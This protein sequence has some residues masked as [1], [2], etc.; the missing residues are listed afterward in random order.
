MMVFAV[1]PNGDKKTLSGCNDVASLKAWVDWSATL[2]SSLSHR[3][4][5]GVRGTCVRDEFLRPRGGR[6]ERVAAAAQP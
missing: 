2:A 1:T 4:G 3:S 5:F 6:P